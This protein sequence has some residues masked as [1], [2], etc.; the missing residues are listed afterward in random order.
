MTAPADGPVVAV[1]PITA[2]QSGEAR[3]VMLT[4]R[5]AQ[6]RARRAGLRLLKRD[7]RPGSEFARF[8]GRSSGAAFILCDD[9]QVIAA[10]DLPSVVAHIPDRRKSTAPPSSEWGQLIDDYMLVL[11]AGGHPMA[12][13]KLR[14]GQLVKMAREVGGHPTELTADRLIAWFGDQPWSTET[15][16]SY[17]AGIRGFLR[18]AYR[19]KRLPVHLADELPKVREHRGMPR[20]TPDLVWRE[21]LMAA[22]PRV[23]LMLRLAAESGLRRGEVARIHTRDLLDGSGPQLLIH[24]KGGKQRI[25]PISDSGARP[26]TG[27]GLAIPQ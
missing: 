16:R 5:N 1:T 8:S 27:R 19:T 10:G 22:D 13:T 17:R 12:S 26:S 23:K 18:W 9:N 21:A 20:P 24:G 2:Q 3:A 25:V 7:P 6:Y 4:V 14:R 11:A 15:R